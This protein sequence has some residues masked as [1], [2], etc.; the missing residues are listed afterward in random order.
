MVCLDNTNTVPYRVKYF[1]MFMMFLWMARTTPLTSF[2][3]GK[4]PVFMPLYLAVLAYF[5]IKYCKYS[6]KPLLLLSSLFLGLYIISCLKYN[7]IQTFS[8]QPIYYLIITHV[9]FNIYNKNDFLFF[10]E[11]VLVWFCTLSLIVWGLA[12]FFPSF[13][14]SFMHR[15]A[16][17]ENHPPTEANSIIVGIGE[18][19]AMG[20]RRNIGFTWE[21][22]IFSCFVILGMYFNLIRNRF[23]IFPVKKNLNFYILLITLLSTLSTTGYTALGVIILFY[24]LNVSTKAKLFV[25]V[26][27]I[28][29]LPSIISLSF[30]SDKIVGLMDIDNEIK[31]V[32]YLSGQGMDV[33]TPQRFGGLY[34]D[35]LNFMNDPLFGFWQNENSHV[36]NMV[37]NGVGIW[38]S[39]GVIQVLA[40][41]G[42]FMGIF[43][44]YNLFKSSKYL[45]R[46]FEYKGQY[47]FA[48]LFILISISYD[49]WENCILM[50]IYFC[51]FYMRYSQ[52]YVKQWNM[53][54]N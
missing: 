16:V 18:S 36:Q 13:F 51:T 22:G 47:M 48:F 17:Y 31:A 53:N 19:F 43:F 6:Y 7:S 9:A 2:N 5:Y 49:F 24:I 52:A 26:L 44:Y 11:K 32:N 35:V 8:F 27:S 4:N 40:R 39:D 42:I 3:F 28:I 12:N 15:I 30:M 10:F 25:V 50:Y 1:Y 23:K 37:F 34:F 38:M 29:A 54:H 46:V 33:I 21:P 14:P 45:S 20:I 41:Y